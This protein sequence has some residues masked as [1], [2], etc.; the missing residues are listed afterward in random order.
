MRSV[1]EVTELSSRGQKFQSPRGDT[2][3]T[4]AHGDLM[5]V[6]DTKGNVIS[7]TDTLLQYD[8]EDFMRGN[9]SGIIAKVKDF[10]T[11]TIEMDSPSSI[12]W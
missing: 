3:F 6:V 10:L 9:Q 5:L 2:T 8:H 1:Q 12:P 11:V 7:P 4:I